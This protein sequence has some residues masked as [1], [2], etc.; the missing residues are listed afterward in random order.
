MKKQ[1]KQSKHHFLIAL[2]SKHNLGTLGQTN[3]PPSCGVTFTFCMLP[4]VTVTCLLRRSITLVS[5]NWEEWVLLNNY[6]V[7]L[8]FLFSQRMR[9]SRTTQNHANLPF[10]TATCALVDINY[11][12]SII[13]VPRRWKIIQRAPKRNKIPVPEFIPFNLVINGL[14]QCT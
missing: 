2:Q 11:V 8:L 5:D 6:F 4:S 1:K 12:S 14:F 3:T 10:N 13:D 7:V 9:K